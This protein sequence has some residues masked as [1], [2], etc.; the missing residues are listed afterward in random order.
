MVDKGD[1]CIRDIRIYD[2]TLTK[3]EIR[4]IAAGKP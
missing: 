4:R 3:S 1:I 2:R